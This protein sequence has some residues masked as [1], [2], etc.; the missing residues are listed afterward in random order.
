MTDS[1]E[2]NGSPS[3]LEKAVAKKSGDRDAEAQVT[4][5]EDESKADGTDRGS[6]RRLFVGALSVLL[7]LA[8]AYIAW[9]A[10]GPA[11][12]GWMQASLAPIMGTGRD[13]KLGTQLAQLA[14]KIEPLEKDITGLKAD[15]AARPVSDPA[16]LLALDDQVRQTGE[17]L[18]ALK[19]EIDTLKRAMFD[20]GSASNISSLSERLAEMEKR[21][22]TFAARPAATPTPGGTVAVAD[23]DALRTQSGER[24]AALEREN[25]ALR[26]VVAALDRRVG[27]IEQKPATVS[28]TT[29]GNALV[30]AVGQLRE[31]VRGTA[32]FT[33]ALQ[34]VETL[35]ENQEILAT[36]VATL[37]AH[38]D[39][40]VP[41][42]IAL[43]L[44]FNRI[45]G[46]IAHETFV[47]KGDGWLDRT[48]G[49]VSRVFTVRRTGSTAAASDDENGRVAR[50]EL[51]LAAGD[52]DN[53]V[54]ILEGLKEPAL[55]YAAPWLKEA[56]ARLAVDAAINTLFTE[57]LARARVT[58]D[59][60]GTPGG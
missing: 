48:L 42:L 32:P 35:A 51:R 58:V 36:P 56:R 26:D 23:L 18:A 40:G 5:A 43:R 59:H 53:A 4:G 28:G 60:K 9:P 2:K 33:V 30:L 15:F 8:I 50:A 34:V 25:V 41:D 46:R 7:L 57:A 1:E 10:W 20:I 11:L 6:G 45:A 52:L 37:K 31:A 13:P 17:R 39:S 55:S 22:A 49:R 24:M 38:A 19:T 12:P 21:L 3:T 47:P 14:A 27:A 44:H 16:R 54:A 29:Q